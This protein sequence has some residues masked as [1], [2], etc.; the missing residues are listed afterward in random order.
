[1]H[2]Q[3]AF[4]PKKTRF[5]IYKCNEIDS[6]FLSPIR[7]KI[8][9]SSAVLTVGGAGASGNCS[10]CSLCPICYS[11]VV[12]AK[13][14]SGS[15]ET[16]PINI[17]LDR[18]SSKRWAVAL[19]LFARGVTTLAKVKVLS[20]AGC[21]RKPALVLLAFLLAFWTFHI[22]DFNSPLWTRSKKI[23]NF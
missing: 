10:A 16:R 9:S 18:F 7:V 20:L 6:V 4:L 13:L 5:S 3:A 11:L 23:N 22:S 15:S 21:F 14:P 1:M 2:S 19:G 12:I 17:Q 8:S